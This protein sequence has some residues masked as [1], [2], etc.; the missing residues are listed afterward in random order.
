M[1]IFSTSRTA[2]LAKDL[3]V[4]TALTSSVTTSARQDLMSVLQ[5]LDAQIALNSSTAATNLSTE[6]TNRTNADTTLQTNI[7]TEITNRTTAVTNEATTRAAADTAEA[8][9]R[10]AAVTALQTQVDGERSPLRMTVTG[11][12]TSVAIA[13]ATQ[14][15]TDSAGNTSTLIVPNSSLVSTFPG[16]S[17]NF[18]TGVITYTGGSPANGSFTPINFSG[19]ASKW[20]KYALVLLPTSPNS[21]LVL[22]GSVFGTTAALATEP[23]FS[24]GILI[25]FVAVQDNGTGGSGTIANI[26]QTSLEQAVA[27]GSGSGSGTG[28]S[29]LDPQLDET[30]LYYTRSDFSIDSTNF[31]GSTTGTNNILGLKYVQLNATQ[32]FTS[33]TLV[34]PQFIADNINLNQAQAKLMYNSGYVDTVPTV[35]F[36]RDGGNTYQT[37]TITLPGN[38]GT[39]DG[40][41]ILADYGWSTVTSPVFTS[42]SANGSSSS[43][44]SVAMIFSPSYQ[45]TVNNITVSIKTTGTTGSVK[46]YIYNASSGIP[47]GSP[48][49]TSFETLVPGQDI[50]S[51]SQ[52]KQF[53]FAPTTLKSGQSYAFV[54]AGTGLGA[55]ISVDQTSTV[56]TWNQSSATNNG[57]SWT[58][59]AQYL[60]YTVTGTGADLRIKIT[61]GTASSQ[62]AGF[63]VNYVYE[64]SPLVGGQASNETHVVT[65][66]EASTG[67]ITLTTCKYTPGA[68]QLV[69]YCNQ[70]AFLSPDFVEVSSSQVQFPVNYFQPGDVIYFVC[71]FGLVDGTSQAL[72]KLSSVYSAIVGSSAQLSGGVA[73][74]S[75]LASALTAFPNGEILVLSGYST[76]EAISITGSPYIIGQ[77]N[78]SAILGNV[79]ISGNYATLSNIR[80][81][82]NLTLSGNGNYVQQCFANTTS[83]ISDTGMGNQK[84]L[85]VGT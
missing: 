44:Q 29:P 59:G 21:I 65:S 36:S 22:N 34:G 40:N 7:N 2:P 79:T 53:T 52:F 46:G 20:A 48:L 43:G 63:G 27:S 57:T 9:T 31:V 25:G 42:G 55:N 66:T 32:T 78:Q 85:I 45:F 5:A 37:A 69:A 19:N 11:S 15:R 35:Q 18:S 73:S 14:T 50:V 75:S 81:S 30:F 72:S 26:L 16:A 17:I 4:D 60:A 84:Q 71:N 64:T 56:N 6:I 3:A 8:N 33:S 83:V 68:R 61:S 62:L 13:A 24:G 80:F 70:H 51:T 10:A 82:G 39:Y 74:Y 49:A 47:T 41:I 28:S 12:N 58:I 23:A 38:T 76:S 54:A 67:L 1:S 77:G